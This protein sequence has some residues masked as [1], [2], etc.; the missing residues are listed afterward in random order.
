MNGMCD[1][2]YSEWEGQYPR[3]IDGSV[4]GCHCSSCK[5][6]RERY[7]NTNI[8]AREGN[9]DQVLRGFVIQMDKH[10]NNTRN[11]RWSRKTSRSLDELLRI[12]EGVSIAVVLP[13]N[14]V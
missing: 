14:K 9:G 6:L 2:E 10:R 5:E 12:Q 13:R 4:I 3:D 7:E 1:A 8:G 11:Q